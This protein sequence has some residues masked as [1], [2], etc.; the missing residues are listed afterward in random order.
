MVEVNFFISITINS[1]SAIFLTREY[2]VLPIIHVISVLG[3]YVCIVF[4]IGI[5]CVMSP[6]DDN[7]RIQIDL[8]ETLSWVIIEDNN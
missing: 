4:I 8:L 3:E 7:L 1:I 6:I 2:S 5:I